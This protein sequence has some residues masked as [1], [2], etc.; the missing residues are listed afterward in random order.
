MYGRSAC[1][2]GVS[3]RI[4]FVRRRQGSDAVPALSGEICMLAA[5]C[6][7][8]SI[9]FDVFVDADQDS[10][11]ILINPKVLAD[12]S[13]DNIYVENF[14]LNIV[15]KRFSEVMWAMQQI[16]FMSFDRRLAVFLCKE[17][18]KTGSNRINLTHEQ[19]ARYLG[20]ARE[21]VSRM[22]KYFSAEG[23]VHL[24]RGGVEIVDMKRL[25]TLAG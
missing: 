4:Y 6:V 23:L 15:A 7:I 8:E 25:K 12:L 1:F 21:V 24:L 20:S 5:S 11:L 2:K 10:E 22:L 19:I 16:L 9:D 3:P 14:S 18:E 17:A 13:R